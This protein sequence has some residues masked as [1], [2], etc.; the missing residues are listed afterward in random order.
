MRSVGEQHALESRTDE[1]LANL[2][3]QLH[4]SL[5]IMELEWIRRGLQDDHR[6]RDDNPP[7]TQRQE[8]HP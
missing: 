8:P 7:F 5:F 4:D 6:F 1:Q 3:K 2:R